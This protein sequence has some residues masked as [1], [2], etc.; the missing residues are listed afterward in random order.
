LL[1]GRKEAE[2]LCPWMGGWEMQEEERFLPCFRGRKGEILGRST[3]GC[4]S[5]KEVRTITKLR[6]DLGC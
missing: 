1:D 5:R 3:I 2:L 6:A 4:F